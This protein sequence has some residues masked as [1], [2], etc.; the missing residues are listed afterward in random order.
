M[1]AVERHAGDA[2]I[3]ADE[4]ARLL[5]S[6]STRAQLDEL[7]RLSVNAARVWAMRDAVLRRT[8]LL[9]EGF[10]REL[11]RRMFRGIWRTAG[12]YRTSERNPG[13]EPHRIAEGVAMFFDD[14]DGWLRFSTFPVH[15]AAVRLHQRLVSMRPWSNGNG[16]HARLV[17]DV[18]VAANGERPLTWGA[19]SAGSPRERYLE[20]VRAAEAGDYAVL[21][22]FARG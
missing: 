16:R 18:V 17:A 12:K 20:A 1:T 15:E 19:F 8:D 4:R 3:S 14:A 21:L 7:E 22:D 10:A 11:H 6:L 2:P 5:P 13:W 9:S